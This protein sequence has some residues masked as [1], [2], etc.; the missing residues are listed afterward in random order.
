MFGYRS[1]VLKVRLIIDRLVVRLVYDRDVWR[2][3][4]YYVENRYFFKFWELVR[5]ESY[6]YLLGWQVRLGMINE[7]YK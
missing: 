4:D 5:D 3:A 2:F 6:C 7:F 1:N